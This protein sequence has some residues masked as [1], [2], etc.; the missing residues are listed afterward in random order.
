MKGVRSGQG[1]KGQ[2]VQRWSGVVGQG[3]AGVQ[4]KG[5]SGCSLSV[6]MFHLKQPSAMQQ[7]FYL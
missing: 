5:Q 1:K 3:K 6:Q 2:G 7:C 4:G